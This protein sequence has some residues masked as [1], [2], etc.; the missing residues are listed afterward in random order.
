MKWGRILLIL[1][2]RIGS[3]YPF[4]IVV[5]I[6]IMD[7]DYHKVYYYIMEYT[8]Y[9]GEWDALQLFNS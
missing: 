9:G 7:T 1:F 3:F 5:E 8:K 4:L 2:K 6:V